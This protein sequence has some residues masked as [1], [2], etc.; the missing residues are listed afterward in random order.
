M[1]QHITRKELKHDRVAETLAHGA[2][3][4]VS[5]QKAIWLWAGVAAV[6]L[7]A[8]FG[9]RFYSER[10]TLKASAALEEAMKVFNARI[11]TA[12]EPEEPGEITYVAENNKFEDAA[13]KFAAVAENYGRT[14]P[15]AVARYYAGLCQEH[16]GRNDEAGKWLRQ[17]ASSSHTEV[18]ALS[19]FQLAGVLAEQGK[20]EE[21]V[22]IYQQLIEKPAL[23]VP[24][25]VVMLAL[26]EHYART[27]PP[28]AVKLYNQLKTEFPNT[29]VAEQAERQLEK[30]QPK[31]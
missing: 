26:A 2:E 28:E 21:A 3:A 4:V 17:A 8:V 31:S 11:R 19:K 18:A 29:A 12:G 5:H 6:I 15:G 13:K 25:P 1:S 20:N 23:F 10:Q 27:N 9:W 7:A 30:L 22:K 14:Q 16:L 24:K